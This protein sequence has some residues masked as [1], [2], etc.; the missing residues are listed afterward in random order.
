M[1]QTVGYKTRLKVCFRAHCGH[2]LSLDEWLQCSGSCRSPMAAF[3]KLN[4]KV[5]TTRQLSFITVSIVP[6]TDIAT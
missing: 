2:S 1:P 6:K 5:L 4:S 3:W